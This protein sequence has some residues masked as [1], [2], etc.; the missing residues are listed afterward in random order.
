[1]NP[2]R[3]R[4]A[5]DESLWRPLRKL[6]QAMDDDIARLYED[7]GVGIQ[8]SHSMV[9]IRL[10]SAGPMTIRALADS[11]AITHS[12]ASQKVAALRRDGYVVDT[13]G[14]DLRT[15][16]IALTD[17]GAELAPFL[18]GEWS[19]TEAASADLEGELPYPLSRAVDDMRQALQR[20]SFHD[21]I[22]ERIDA[23]E[24]SGGPRRSPGPKR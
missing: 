18:A 16:V 20:N 11:L 10:A 1:M 17:R 8:T 12:A 6:L 2:D 24:S 9:I 14:S 13:A 21:R 15:K 7:R 23:G 19:A 5:V 22:V 3:P 4:D